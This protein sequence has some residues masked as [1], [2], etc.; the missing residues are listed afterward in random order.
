MDALRKLNFRPPEG[1]EAEKVRKVQTLSLFIV[2]PGQLLSW[3]LPGLP[4]EETRALQEP[5]AQRKL[6]S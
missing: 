5:L 2:G 6:D 3:D 1:M 4:G